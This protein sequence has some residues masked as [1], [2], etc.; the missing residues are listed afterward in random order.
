[1]IGFLVGICVMYKQLRNANRLLTAIIRKIV[2]S[3]THANCRPLCCVKKD[4][5]RFLSA[6]VTIMNKSDTFFLS[7]ICSLSIV[8][9][10]D[11]KVGS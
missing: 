8:H 11:K 2:F 9:L 7:I 6:V 3:C 4:T 10:F 1:M 5:E